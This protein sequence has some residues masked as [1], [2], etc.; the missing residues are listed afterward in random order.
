M[1]AFDI[2]QQAFPFQ[3]LDEDAYPFRGIDEERLDRAA[4]PNNFGAWA[5]DTDDATDGDDNGL[6]LFSGGN[7]WQADTD[8]QTDAA[9]AWF[10]RR[11]G[12]VCPKWKRRY[13]DARDLASDWKKKARRR[14]AEIQTLRRSVKVAKDKLVVIRKQRES[15]VKRAAHLRRKYKSLR[16]KYDKLAAQG[17]A[18]SKRAQKTVADLR[19]VVANLQAVKAEARELQ[20]ANDAWV[21]WKDEQMRVFDAAEAAWA[22]QSQ[23]YAPQPPQPG[24]PGYLPP[25][26]AYGQTPEGYFYAAETPADWS[27]AQAD[28]SQDEA[29]LRAG[30]ALADDSFGYVFGGVVDGIGGN[31]VGADP[32]ADYFGRFGRCGCAI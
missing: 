1:G 19:G 32:Y 11:R 5:A 13:Y 24:V 6:A 3:G 9:A 15:G 25:Q 22:Q 23:Q 12:G 29:F 26:A 30:S 7:A 18:R 14:H 27:S 10:G 17:K 21:V 16:R 2:V 28:A 8:A 4:F 20:K 31:S